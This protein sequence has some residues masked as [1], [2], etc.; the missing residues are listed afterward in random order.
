M[1][2][3]IR[4]LVNPKKRRS[5]RN[6]RR[7]RR[8]RLLPIKAKT[9]RKRGSY[10]LKP[11]RKVNRPRKRIVRH[12]GRNPSLVL[13][14]LNP[15][16]TGSHYMKKKKKKNARHHYKLKAR[17]NPS[18]VRHHR[19]YRL[20]RRG[21]P[22]GITW[23]KFAEN[24]LE[25]LFGGFGARLIPQ[26]ALPSY[27]NGLP[28]Y[29]MNV[30]STAVLA[31]LAEMVR[32]GAGLPVAL[33]GSMMTLSRIVSDKWG[34]TLVTFGV[35]DQSGATA[36]TAAVTA[37]AATTSQLSQGDLAFDLR[38]YKA[39]YFP[40][41]TKSQSDL[42][43]AVPWAGDIATLKAMIAAKGKGAI[44]PGAQ[45]TATSTAKS[46]RYGPIM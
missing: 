6:R 45:A 35:T 1:P 17:R 34:K 7:D 38:G 43:T 24:L 25:V 21:N 41:P 26:Y 5:L 13:M 12:E 10:S 32:K 39:T 4:K 3:R 42:T 2:V 29:G 15:V 27:N 46:G 40:L 37:P 44:T 36:G 22:F 8:G 11:R 16:R 31:Y 28:G 30:V 14:G 9:N 19:S 20:R 23:G 33:G 18:G